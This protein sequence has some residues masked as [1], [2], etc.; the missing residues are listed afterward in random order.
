MQRRTRLVSSTPLVR[1]SPLRDWP[2]LDRKPTGDRMPLSRRHKPAVPTAV[3]AT[4]EG[5]SGGVCEAKLIGCLGRATDPHHRITVKAGGRR[6]DARER[7]DRLSN[8]LHLCRLCHQWVTT[9]PA[10]SREV[11]LALAEWQQPAMEPVL[12]RGGMAYLTDDGRVVPF[13]EVGP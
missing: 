2:A 1:R 10:E 12:Y 5:R 13:E 6:G 4:L 8:V 9:R 11:G 3:R 7:H